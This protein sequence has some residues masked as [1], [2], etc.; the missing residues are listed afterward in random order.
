MGIGHSPRECSPL[1]LGE[2]PSHARGNLVVVQEQELP[3]SEGAEQAVRS[4][5]FFNR[6]QFE[7][8]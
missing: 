7:S 1:H 4:R 5:V 8:R 3:C 2:V 6:W